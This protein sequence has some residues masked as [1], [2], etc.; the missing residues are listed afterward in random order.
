MMPPPPATPSTKEARNTPTI[1][2]STI[3]TVSSMGKS[4][5]IIPA[6]SF[7]SIAFNSTCQRRYSS[8]AL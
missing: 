5:C 6:Y 4:A 3:G 1:T 7:S 2:I 8:S